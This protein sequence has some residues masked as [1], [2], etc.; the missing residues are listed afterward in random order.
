MKVVIL[1]GGRGTRIQGVEDGVPKPMIPVGDRPILWHVMKCYMRYGFNE[2]VL[3]LGYKQETIRDWFLHFYEYTEDLVK[4]Y[5]MYTSFPQLPYT[6]ENRFSVAL[7]DTGLDTMTGGRVRRIEKWIGEDEDFMLTYGDGVGNVNVKD[8]VEWHKSHGKILTITGVRPPGRFGEL[9][10]EKEFGLVTGFNEK[11]QT[12]KG[13]INGGFMVCR[14]GIFEY[15]GE[16][17]VLEGLPM[18]DLVADKE[19]MVYRHNGFWQCMDTPR[20]Y[21]ML[22][23]M[24]REEVSPWEE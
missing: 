23:K 12:T 18:L 3:A 7:V 21:E 11:S 2:F 5:N 17:D 8:L 4:V 9:E 20:D 22:N 15:L 19:V 10:Y 1:C 6:E 24:A 13:R 16:D 14:R